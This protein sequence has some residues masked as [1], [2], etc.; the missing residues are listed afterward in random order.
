MTGQLPRTGNRCAKRVLQRQPLF[1]NR[2]RLSRYF[3]PSSGT[4]ICNMRDADL[5]REYLNGSEPAF[6]ELVS[7]YLALVYGTAQRQVRDAQLAQDVTQTVFC[8]LARKARSFSKEASLA[9]WLYRAASFTAAKAVRG[10]A[11]RRRRERA[12]LEMNNYQT[13]SAD[14]WEHGTIAHASFPNSQC[15]DSVTSKWLVLNF[16][17]APSQL[18]PSFVKRN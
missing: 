2:K 17:S 10:E 16:Q 6:E 3:L 11:R 14:V 18:S 9:G 12:T 5:L 4:N 7:R 15:E 1:S 13:E 8:L